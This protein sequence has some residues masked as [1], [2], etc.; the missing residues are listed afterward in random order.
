MQEGGK[1]WNGV[2]E[3]VKLVIVRE[4]DADD[5]VTWRQVMTTKE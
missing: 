4:G 3:D 2:K 5:R 1:D